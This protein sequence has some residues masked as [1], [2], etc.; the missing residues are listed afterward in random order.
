MATST[1]KK[2]K[3]EKSHIVDAA[4][5]LLHEGK[6]KVNE[7]YENQ[8][9]KIA[10]VEENIKSYSE[11]LSHKV[12]ESPLTSLLIAGGIGFLIASILKK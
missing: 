9:Q 4:S 10:E 12:K 11:D 2:S 3:D 8:T 5:E 6:K 1:F 7:L